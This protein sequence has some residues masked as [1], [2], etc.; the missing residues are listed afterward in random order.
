MYAL[1]DPI[2]LQN[3]D[4]DCYAPWIF[5]VTEQ[6][7]RQLVGAKTRGCRQLAYTSSL[8]RWAGPLWDASDTTKIIWDAIGNSLPSLCFC[9]VMIG[10]NCKVCFACLSCQCQK[11]TNKTPGMLSESVMQCIHDHRLKFQPAKSATVCRSALLFISAART[12]AIAWR[13]FSPD[14]DS[15]LGPVLGRTCTNSWNEPHW[16]PDWIEKG[17]KF[18]ELVWSDTQVSVS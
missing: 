5:V 7:C 6:G 11:S 10:I 4:P 13:C 18:I 14:L 8:R 9:N 12:S 15:V 16:V 3:D 2:K 17:W 1:L